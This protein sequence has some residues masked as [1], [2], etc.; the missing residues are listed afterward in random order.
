MGTSWHSYPKI[1]NLGHAALAELFDG[2]VVI[3]EK[4][5]GS[6]FSFGVFDGVVKCRSKGCEL[7]VEAPEKMFAKAV[8]Q[9]LD[10][11]HLLVDGWTYRGEYL[12]SPKHNTLAYDR[13]PKDHI[14]LFDINTAEERYIEPETLRSVARL[15][16]FECV[17]SITPV[18]RDAAGI[19]AAMDTISVLGG[20]KIEGIV[21]KNYSK[22]GPDKKAL[23]GK[24][25]S[26]AFKEIH[27]ADWKERHPTKADLIQVLVD[28]YRTP[29]R[30]AKAVQH[31]KE[32]G[33]IEGTPK[34]IGE[35]MKE[36]RR[37][38]ETECGQEI[39]DAL[40]AQA[41]PKILG[42][43]IKGLPEWYKEQLLQAQQF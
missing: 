14:I 28:R 39:R 40:W 30:W 20:Q 15:I 43:A 3:Q 24:H 27:G 34:D 18:S 23:M 41:G 9:V 19:I 33:K 2:E 16:D 22:F 42:G 32:A 5:D 11:K 38:L 26:E 36:A 21:V 37:D 35:L 8:A 6:Q 1:Y 4:I 31:L 17:P 13:T 10:R 29:A 12:Q 7:V 25:V